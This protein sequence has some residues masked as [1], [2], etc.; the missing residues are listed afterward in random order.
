MLSAESRLRTRLDSALRQTY[1][2]RGFESALSQERAVMM[3]EV[4]N[5]LRPE[6]QTL[7]LE[8]VD[9]RIRRT[10]IDERSLRSNL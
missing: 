6:A 2:K 3:Q 10:E 9:V 1:G 4:R 5:Q 7:G 8:I